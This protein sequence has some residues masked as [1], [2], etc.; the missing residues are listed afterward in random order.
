M[1]TKGVKWVGIKN[2]EGGEEAIRAGLDP[3][4]KSDA[5]EHT[6]KTMS[7]PLQL[8]QVMYYRFLSAFCMFSIFP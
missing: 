2:I 8:L 4:N 5:S 7:R 3:T 6:F 1:L